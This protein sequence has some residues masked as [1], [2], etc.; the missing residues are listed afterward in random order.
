MLD[1]RLPGYNLMRLKPGWKLVYEDSLA[2]VFVRDKAELV[3]AFAAANPALPPTGRECAFDE[4]C[5]RETSYLPG[6]APLPR[7]VARA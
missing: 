3:A 7:C 5:R 6:R 4:S 2:A 1:K